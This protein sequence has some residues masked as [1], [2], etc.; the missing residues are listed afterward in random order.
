MS[1]RVA[2][3]DPSQRAVEPAATR[4]RFAGLALDGVAPL[5]ILLVV[6]G[7]LRFVLLGSRELFRDEAA[8]WLLSRADWSE[9]LPRAAAEPYAPVYAYALK[10]WTAILGDGEATL[11]GLSACAGVAMVAVTW[12]WGR[13]AMGPRAAFIAAGLVSL[14]PLAISNAREARMYALESLFIV[15]AWWLLW[16]LVVDQRPL[17]RRP[18]A[19]VL[20]AA[21]TAA[22]LWTLPVGIGA[23]VLQ[24]LAVAVLL[25][26]MPSAGVRAAALVLIAGLL[27][28]SPW[29]P[30]LLTAADSSRPFW[31]PVPDLGDLP[32][33]VAVAFTGQAPSAAW[34]AFLPLAA[35]GVMGVWRL[36]REPGDGPA[37][38]RLPTAVMVSAGSALILLWW[39]VSQWRPAYDTRYLGAAVPPLAMAISVGS[40]GLA[41][42]WS[43]ASGGPRRARLAGFALATLLVSG[44]AVFVGGWLSGNGL[45]PARAA[46]ALL[47]A[48]VQAGD[49]V[50]AVDARSYFPLAYLT[51][52]DAERVELAGPLRY[53]RTGSEPAFLGADLIPE[54]DRVAAQPDLVEGRLP[55]LAPTGSIW[56]VAI[57]DP[58]N[59]VRDFAP[60]ADGRVTEEERLAVIDN[61]LSGLILR[62]RPAP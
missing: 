40:M 55:G 15:L 59:E 27:A 24:S 35:L 2:P 58:L 49:V 4:Q 45:E 37:A 10:A 8:S 43:R 16:R 57:T 33:T 61:G 23:F 19:I 31:T 32:E 54:Q 39:I 51:R 48:R 26:R 9:I 14:S 20:A 47:G 52:R 41:A 13:S 11:R 36:F 56:L 3:A 53:W 6:A 38:G 30:R 60:L 5:L 62:L 34:L 46:G 17:R 7:A 28:F 44:T 22:E 50:I 29:L 18:L 21:A 25:L 42:R 12:V 1:G